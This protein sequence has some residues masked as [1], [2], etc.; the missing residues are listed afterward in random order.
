MNSPIISLNNISLTFGGNPLLDK[1]SVQISKGDKIC[2]VGRNGSGKSTLLKILA[3]II[4]ID[5]GEYFV[6]PGIK[7]SYLMQDAQFTKGSAIIDLAQQ[8]EETYHETMA[9]FDKLGLDPM[10]LVDTLSGGER[11]RVALAQSLINNPD[12]LL[13]DEPTN[14][15]DLPAIEWLEDYLSQYKGACVTISHDRA[16]LRKVSTSTIW[17]DGGRLHPH[18]KGFSDF[19]AWSERILLDQEKHV[20]RLDNKLRQEAEWLHRGVT[21]RRKRNQGRLRQL[22]QLRETKQI[23]LN[24]Q[25]GKGKLLNID[26]EKGSQLITE[27][28]SI[29]K[30]FGERVVIKDFSTRIVR[31]ER[32]GVIGPNGAGKTTL[33]K[34]LIG[35]IAP[36][37]GTVKLGTNL[38]WIYFDQL[39]ESLN[40]NET[41]WS[42]MCEGGGDQVMVQGQYRHVVGYLK[43]FLFNDRQI[44][45]Q[46]SILSGGEKNR[47]ALAKA[48]AQPGNVL[49]L[50]EPTNDLDM[51]T[52]DLLIDILS[53]YAGT[54]IMV[55]H[56]RDFLDKLTTSIIAVERSGT[57]HEYIGGYQDYLRQRPAVVSS[58]VKKS[59]A[60]EKVN[61][62]AKPR[63]SYQQKRD[64]ETFPDKIDQLG[65]E[66]VSVENKLQDPNL[67][68]NNNQEYLALSQKL[69]KMREDLSHMEMRW[70]ELDELA[71]AS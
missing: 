67:Y 6:Q 65:L 14:H 66:I 5:S 45:G 40:L 68:E 29:G 21:A 60:K 7:I 46:V 17:L 64:L 30:V 63:L 4:E 8:N 58:S 62:V 37:S 38:Q 53:D 52:L 69:E 1:L 47:L 48:F 31:G 42:T 22:Y 49:V 57:V 43:D 36:D 9:M 26:G 2:L 33:V 23:Q 51:D 39:R 34:M 16:F 3:G 44:L 54:L 59:V 55:S 19:D 56:D 11:R 10:R 24:S 15:L 70:L 50:D 27:V 13:L 25:P 71:N 20:S 41:L 18:N 35:K 12:V 28:H 32:I 61:V